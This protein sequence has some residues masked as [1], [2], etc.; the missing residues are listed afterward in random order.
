MVLVSLL[1]LIKD[2]IIFWY[3]VC[4]WHV[5]QRGWG[6]WKVKN[7]FTFALYIWGT[8]ATSWEVY[9][10]EDCA[11]RPD[12]EYGIFI[13]VFIVSAEKHFWQ[14]PEVQIRTP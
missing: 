13:L 6:V 4:S 12:T 11:T 7:V 5:E 14:W 2:L 1:L 10:G 8:Q 3:D 9:I